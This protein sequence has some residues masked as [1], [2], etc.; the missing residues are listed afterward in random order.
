MRGWIWLT[1]PA[2]WH[3]LAL[4]LLLGICCGVLSACRVDVAEA[5]KQEQTLNIK[6]YDNGRVQ[7]TSVIEQG[8]KREELLKWA[9]AN[10][11][12]W[13]LAVAD[14]VPDLLVYDKNVHLN[15][16]PSFAVFRSGWLQY[17]KDVSDTDYQ[18]LRQ[19]L[20]AAPQTSTK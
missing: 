8:T 14:Y 9:E 20:A 2:V 17:S 10:P 18:H 13:S 6:I 16:R 7:S 5:L 19:V 1:G 3:K 4:T 15:I 11:D 12:G